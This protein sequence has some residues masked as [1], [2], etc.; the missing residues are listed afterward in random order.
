[1]ALWGN[2]DSKG[3]GGTVSLNY[4]S[5]TVTGSGT[6][7]GQVGAAA[8]GDV[9]RF[10]D[11]AGVYFGDA[12]IVGIASTTQLSIA[13]TS[14][15]SGVAV[16]ATTFNISQ[17]PKFTTL[18]SHYK[19]GVSTTYDALVYGVDPNEANSTTYGASHAG[20]VGVTTYLDWEG[21]MR[22]KSE[23]LVAM[24]SIEGDAN[25]D[26]VFP[27]RLISII[28]QPTNRTGILTTANTTFTV[29]ASSTPTAS[30]AYQWQYSSTGV[31]YTN[32]T[33][34]GI[35]NNVTTTTVGIASTTVTATR[36]DGYYFRVGVSTSDATTVFSNAATLTYV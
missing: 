23:V 10:G 25:D 27:D 5:L 16:A 21:N 4:S 28:T 26:I 22:V 32:L 31:A 6:T 2:I 9:I 3:S 11:T 29:A 13:S 18:D 35:Y 20:W 34:T 19:A 33:N 36:P 14:N 30:L 1:M 15:L 24:S 8:T 7:F 12:V 17:L